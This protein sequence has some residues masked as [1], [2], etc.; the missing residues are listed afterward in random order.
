M[1]S[2]I[3]N[4]KGFFKPYK[5]LEI[6]LKLGSILLGLG[7]VIYVYGFGD[8]LGTMVPRYAGY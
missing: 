1:M 5:K 2:F 7:Y 8:G 4:I 6:W 3:E